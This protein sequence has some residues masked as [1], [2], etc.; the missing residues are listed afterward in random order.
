MEAEPQSQALT[1]S[2]Y[3]RHPLNVLRQPFLHL[4]PSTHAPLTLA[5]NTRRGKY[6]EKGK[7]FHSQKQIGSAP[8]DLLRFAG[9][10][11]ASEEVP[12]GVVELH[13]FEVHR[14]HV[15]VHHGEV[16]VGALALLPVKCKTHLPFAAVDLL[17]IHVPR[18]TPHIGMI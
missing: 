8:V 9:E 13:V 12:D 17:K 10:A 7:T 18:Y 5:S 4:Q 11:E 14:V 16:E 1:T 6:R 15:R 2:N 3:A